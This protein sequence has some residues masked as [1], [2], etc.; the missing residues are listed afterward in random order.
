MNIIT[1]KLTRFSILLETE[2]T[3]RQSAES[4][5]NSKPSKN[6]VYVELASCSLS[7]L[8]CSPPDKPMMRIPKNAKHIPNIS[9]LEKVS[10]NQQ[11]A[12]NAVVKIF[13][14]KTTKKTPR[15]TKLTL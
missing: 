5:V 8:S 14:L 6:M 11:N 9:N 2:I 15:G 12:R 13:E 10:F 3:L 7:G 4:I 1:A